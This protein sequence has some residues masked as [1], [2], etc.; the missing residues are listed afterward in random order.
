MIRIKVEFLPGD[1]EDKART[2][3]MM[4]IK[5][6]KDNLDG[7]YDYIYTYDEPSPLSGP[8]FKTYGKLQSIRRPRPLLAII[9]QCIEYVL[10]KGT[11]VYHLSK[12]EKAEC[13]Y[14]RTRNDKF[15]VQQEEDK[16]NWEMEKL[17]TLRNNGGL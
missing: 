6:I 8:P 1:N 14:M 15:F 17:N 5:N 12:Q 9:H 3:A 2:I 7:T 11:M 10:F 13:E 16:F 4:N